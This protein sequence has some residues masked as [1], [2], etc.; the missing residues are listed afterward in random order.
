[1]D[2]HSVLWNFRERKKEK[3][4]EELWRRLE[5][6]EIKSGGT[7]SVPNPSPVIFT[8]PEGGLLKA[9]SQHSSRSTDT[10]ETRENGNLGTGGTENTPKTTTTTTTTTGKGAAQSSDDTSPRSSTRKK[11]L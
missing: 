1:M 2:D 3:D 4:R 11:K 9:A 6:L 10:N 5:Q 7:N 8:S